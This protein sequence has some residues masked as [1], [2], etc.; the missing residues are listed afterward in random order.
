MILCQPFKVFAKFLMP[1]VWWTVGNCKG[2][3][4]PHVLID[5]HDSSMFDQPDCMT[6]NAK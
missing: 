6:F 3:L 1:H 5:N 4:V 2:L